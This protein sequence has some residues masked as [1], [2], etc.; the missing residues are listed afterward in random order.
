MLF[1]LNIENA[2]AHANDAYRLL[3]TRCI[4]TRFRAWTEKQTSRIRKQF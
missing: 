2:L 4:L 3:E 1:T